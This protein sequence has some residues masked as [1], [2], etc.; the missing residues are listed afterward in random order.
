MQGPPFS[1][2]VPEVERLYAS[3]FH[4]TQRA[5]TDVPG[6][7]KGICPATEIAWHLNPKST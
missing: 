3:A 5:K 2:D 1:I 6:G 7:L 4:L